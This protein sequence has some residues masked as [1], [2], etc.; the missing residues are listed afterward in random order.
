MNWIIGFFREGQDM[1][2]PDR[3]HVFSSFL[4]V[5]NFVMILEFLDFYSVLKY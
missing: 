4:A 2:S 3:K 5:E 1:Q